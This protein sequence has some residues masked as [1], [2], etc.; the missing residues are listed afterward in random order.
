MAPDVV[1]ERF[2]AAWARPRGWRRAFETY[3]THDI[4][5]ENVGISSTIGIDAA[6]AFVES[7]LPFTTMTVDT[8]RTLGNARLV[9]NERID[10]FLDINGTEIL[11]VRVMGLFELTEGKISL[12][13]DYCDVSALKGE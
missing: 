5:W 9:M 8:I 1:V 6:C 2:L 4:V 13:R 3:C 12:W 10:R 11:A 7:N